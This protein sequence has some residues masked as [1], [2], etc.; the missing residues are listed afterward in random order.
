ME[1]IGYDLYRVSLSYWRYMMIPITY[2]SI[3]KTA[4]TGQ[5]GSVW[6]NLTRDASAV[7]SKNYEHTTRDGHVKGFIIN[8]EI[9]GTS[10]QFFNF[11]T[12]PNTWKFRN[13]FRKFHAYRDLMFDNAGVTMDERGRYGKTIRPYLSDCHRKAE[14]SY[15]PEDSSTLVIGQP[16]VVSCSSTGAMKRGEWTYSKLATT[17]LYT[18]EAGTMGSSTLDVADEFD[19]TICDTNQ[20]PTTQSGTSGQY[21]SVG[22]IHSYNLDR[23]EVFTPDAS[24]GLTIEGPQNPL[25]ALIASGNQAAGEILEIVQDQELEKPPYDTTDNGDSIK[26]VIVGFDKVPTTVGITRGQLFVPAGILQILPSSTDSFIF[27]CEILAEVLCKDM[28]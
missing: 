14:I 11:V 19:L 18:E 16:A 24:P 3:A 17:P 28:A 13:A 5:N 22:M 7:S 23:M 25:A 27:R 12:A 8:Y 10:G 20:V 15:N 2:N 26:A 21:D 4:T 1:D 9:I 6:F